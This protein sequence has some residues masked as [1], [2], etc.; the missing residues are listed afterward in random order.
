[1]NRSSKINWKLGGLSYI[2]ISIIFF[3]AFFYSAFNNSF[4]IDHFAAIPGN[5]NWP[6]HYVVYPS[7]AL[8][9][10]WTW[11]LWRVL[12]LLIWLGLGAF[13]VLLANDVIGNRKG[14]FGGWVASKATVS[15]L[16]V[17][18]ISIA[19]FFASYSNKVAGNNKSIITPEQYKEVQGDNSALKSLFQKGHLY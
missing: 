13:M 1:M 18:V 3:F 10:A 11:S 19:L 7:P 2:A 9:F 12:G 14:S 8:V 5:S 17:V 15:F 6:E 16:A 4:K